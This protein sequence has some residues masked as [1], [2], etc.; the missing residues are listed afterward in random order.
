MSPY[1][2]LVH[3]TAPV[4]QP[5][6]VAEEAKPTVQPVAA[7]EGKP[8]DDCVL[9]TMI[10]PDSS[11]AGSIPA[12]VCLSSAEAKAMGIRPGYT[13]GA[14]LVAAKSGQKTPLPIRVVPSMPDVLPAFPAPPKDGE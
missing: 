10:V 1:A 8:D 9:L 13:P 6:P 5:A 3:S 7:C 4:T 12:T 14:L 2:P 11:G